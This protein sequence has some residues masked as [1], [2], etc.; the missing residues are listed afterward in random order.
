M[1]SSCRS[2]DRPEPP[3]SQHTEPGRRPGKLSSSMSRCTGV[4][5]YRCTGLDVQVYIYR[6]TCLDVQVYIYIGVHV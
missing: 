3:E 2:R 1:I 5:I 4:Y 6:C